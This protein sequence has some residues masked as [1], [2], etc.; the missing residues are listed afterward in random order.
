MDKIFALLNQMEADG[1]IGQ[2]AIGGAVGAIFWL[3]PF[4]TK[5]LDVFVTLPT[6]EGSSLLTLG[7]IYSY[8]MNRG[9]QPSGQFIVIE[10]WAEEFVPH[11]TPLVEEALE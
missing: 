6:G 11:A 9:Y 7:P 10:G 1:V 3:E 2:Y 4:A 8:L 5:D